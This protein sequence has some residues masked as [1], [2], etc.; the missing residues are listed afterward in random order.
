MILWTKNVLYATL[1]LLLSFLGVAGLYVFAGAAFLGVAQIMVYI[2]GIIV[3]LVFGV[4]F[5]MRDQRGEV[6]SKSGNL[7]LGI[8]AGAGMFGLLVWVFSHADFPEPVG[9]SEGVA[10]SN[11]EQVG[12]AMMSDFIVPFEFA[13]VLL[14]VSLIAAAFIA[15]KK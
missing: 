1:L 9:S 2:G 3:L 10:R 5:T 7:M 4:M 14:L 12:I 6:T 11:V 8:A 13:G 15:G